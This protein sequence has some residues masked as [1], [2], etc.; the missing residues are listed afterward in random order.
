[1]QCLLHTE[2]DRSRVNINYA[3]GST[4][5]NICHV[6]SKEIFDLANPDF[7]FIVK[8]TVKLVSDKLYKSN[9]FLAVNNTIHRKQTNNSHVIY[10]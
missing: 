9:K 7:P 8:F 4:T 10:Y 3:S 6:V 1:M 2:I 5:S